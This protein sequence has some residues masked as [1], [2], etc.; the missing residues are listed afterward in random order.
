MESKGAPLVI[1]MAP[2]INLSPS[3][4]HE[5]SS[6][7]M[8]DKHLCNLLADLDLKAPQTASNDAIRIA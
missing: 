2:S 3:I 6:V 4:E 1:S 7:A 5:R 8:A